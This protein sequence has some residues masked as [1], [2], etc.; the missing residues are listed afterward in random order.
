MPGLDRK[1]I[2]QV[3][4]EGVIAHVKADVRSDFILAPHYNAIFNKA[5]DDLWEQLSQQLR[6]G[7]YQP[8]LPITMSVP[9]ERF[10]T[11]PGSILRPADRLLYQGLVDHVMDRLEDGLD[12]TRSFSHIPTDDDGRMF[13]PNHDRGN[14]SKLR[15][16]RYAMGASSS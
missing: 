12:R 11:R 15:L 7:T 5:G 9:K 4:H 16:P 1:M 8:D 13:E 6:A 2:A 3:D 14:G 10:F